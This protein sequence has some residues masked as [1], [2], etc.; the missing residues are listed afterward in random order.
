[1]S[2]VNTCNPQQFIFFATYE[3]AQEARVYNY[4]RLEK[5]AMDKHSSLLG[6]LICYDENEVARGSLF[7]DSS[8]REVLLKGKAQ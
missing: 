4:N 6:P 7:G 3:C 8:S 5:L 2:M 1:M